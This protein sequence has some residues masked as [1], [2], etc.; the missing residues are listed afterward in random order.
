MALAISAGRFI[1]LPKQMQAKA[2]NQADEL[3][4]GSI[5]FVLNVAIAFIELGSFTILCHVS[6]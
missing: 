4:N 2:Y 5:I 3:K 1:A 6:K